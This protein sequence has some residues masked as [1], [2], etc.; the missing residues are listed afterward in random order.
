MWYETANRTVQLD[1]I[2]DAKVSTVFLGL[3]HGFS[4]AT[5]PVLWETMIFGGPHDGYQDRCS[6]FAE[7]VEMHRK[8]VRVANG[9]E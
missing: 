5:D 8:A 4:R 9:E 6:T 2:G 7:A 3:D 1:Q